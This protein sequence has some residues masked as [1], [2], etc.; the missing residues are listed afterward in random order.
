MAGTKQGGLK[1]SQ[2]NK[3]RYGDD[4]YR[5]IGANGGKKSRGGGF[6]QDSDLASLAGRLGGL[7][8]RRGNPSPLDETAISQAKIQIKEYRR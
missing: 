2:T 4:F 8:S 3:L 6:A 7:K 5:R 1:A